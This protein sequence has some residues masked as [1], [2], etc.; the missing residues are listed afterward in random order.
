MSVS[1]AM[2][3]KVAARA[4]KEGKEIWAQITWD[5]ERG[6]IVTIDD[7]YVGVKTEGKEMC[8]MIDELDFLILVSESG[9]ME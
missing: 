6:R 9:D 3:D 5:D 7:D 8:V 1:K 4:E 2:L